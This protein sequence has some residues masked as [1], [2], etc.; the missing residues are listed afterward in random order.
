MAE[1]IENKEWEPKF[2]ALVCNWCTYAGA[3]L[4]GISRI[5]YP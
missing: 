2:V 5:Q 4:A 1:N 3:D